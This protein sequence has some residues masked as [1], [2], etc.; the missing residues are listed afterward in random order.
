MGPLPIFCYRFLLF[1]I[2]LADS[3]SSRLTK[4]RLRRPNWRGNC[5]NYNYR[6]AMASS[7]PSNKLSPRQNF[8]DRRIAPLGG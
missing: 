3:R 4:L 5:V 8:T 2:G 1:A 7:S 6:V